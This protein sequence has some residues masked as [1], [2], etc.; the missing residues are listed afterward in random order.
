MDVCRGYF[1]RTSLF[2]LTEIIDW[3]T[4]IDNCLLLTWNSTLFPSASVS[5]WVKSSSPL[6]FNHF[7]YLSLLSHLIV[8][9]SRIGFPL[10]PYTLKQSFLHGMVILDTSWLNLIFGS[11]SHETSWREEMRHIKLLRKTEREELLRILFIHISE[12]KWTT[13]VYHV[14]FG[15]IPRKTLLRR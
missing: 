13:F 11:P 1:P 12:N 10:F 14:V 5:K 9:R 3:W 6:Q 15:I 8:I 7:I 2:C 4:V